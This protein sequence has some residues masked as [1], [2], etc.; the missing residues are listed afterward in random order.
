MYFHGAFVLR[1]VRGKSK[2]G[3]PGARP[4]SYGA[5]GPAGPCSVERR[6]TLD[7][8][9]FAVETLEEEAQRQ[10]IPLHTLLRH[11]VLYYLAE[12]PSGRVAVRVPSLP[13]SQSGAAVAV[14]VDLDR[15]EWQRFEHAAACE[16]V[17]VPAL[18]RHAA[19][20]YVADC[21]SGRVGTRL[22]GVP[23]R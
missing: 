4:A 2:A 11:A 15:R 7:L 12:R 9:P 16:R 1:K 5:R 10:R 17:S 20:L 14:A 21:D 6:L 22:L 23:A 3:V 8:A 19:A 13:D 18:M